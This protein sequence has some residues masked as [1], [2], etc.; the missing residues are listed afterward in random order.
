MT[1]EIEKAYH[2]IDI[3]N[4]K[5]LSITS[6]SYIPSVP[7]IKEITISAKKSRNFQTYEV[8]MTAEVDPNLTEEELAVRIRAIQARCRLLA[9]EQFTLD[10][11]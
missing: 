10:K 11:K 8:A 2:G 4:G 1:D 7:R 3:T 9:M 5:D 6:E